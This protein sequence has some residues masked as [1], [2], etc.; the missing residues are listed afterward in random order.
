MNVF[1]GRSIYR[2]YNRK[3]TH[4]LDFDKM[5]CNIEGNSES[6]LSMLSQ[7]S[8]ILG[9]SEVD[10]NTRKKR[11]SKTAPPENSFSFDVKK[12]SWE[13]TDLDDYFSPTFRRPGYKFD[14]PGGEDRNSPTFR[15]PSYKFGSGD[16]E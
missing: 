5:K 15:R 8:L 7:S 16:P 11:N 13:N 10:D 3:D 9:I 4:D 14:S 2:L 1:S 12:K 6:E